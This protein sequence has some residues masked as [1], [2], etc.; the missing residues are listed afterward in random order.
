[1]SATRLKGFG[2][3]NLY[4]G[5][6]GMKCEQCESRTYTVWLSAEELA[7]LPAESG[8]EA[9]LKICEDKLGR[10][11]CTECATRLGVFDREAE[12]KEMFTRLDGKVAEESGIS[13]SLLL[14]NEPL[15]A[16]MDIPMYQLGYLSGTHVDKAKTLVRQAMAVNK[17]NLD[18]WYGLA[19]GV[20]EIF[21]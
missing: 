20:L 14:G 2:L 3:S 8:S 19:D 21:K 7:S 17:G 9:S 15:K 11:L 6:N 10:V 13:V 16:K 12:L 18:F 5:S 4:A 1:M